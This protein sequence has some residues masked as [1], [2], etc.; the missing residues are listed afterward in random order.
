M[1]RKRE[2]DGMGSSS[3]PPSAVSL[4]SPRS[5]LFIFFSFFFFPAE[6]S[7]DGDGGLEVA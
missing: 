2:I 7:S 6:R 5:L 4:S 3:F 1:W